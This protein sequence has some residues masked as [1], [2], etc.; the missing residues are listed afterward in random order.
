MR[1]LINAQI[2]GPLSGA[3]RTWPNDRAASAYDPKRSF[4]RA[5]PSDLPLLRGIAL[6][7][8]DQVGNEIGATLILTDTC[9]HRALAL[10]DALSLALSCTAYRLL[11]WLAQNGE[12][13]FD[14]QQDATRGGLDG[15][16]PL[17]D[18][19]PTGFAHCGNSYERRLAGLS[20]ILEVCLNTFHEWTSSRLGGGASNC[21][22]PAARLY[23]RGILAKSGGYRQQH[24]HCKSQIIPSHVGLRSFERADKR[25]HPTVIRFRK[26]NRSPPMLSGVRTRQITIF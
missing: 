6:H 9:G 20:E 10:L 13:F 17:V 3:K 25:N 5:K 21:Y 12:V 2:G 19:R 22:V 23:D 1:V 24:E 7:G 4:A 18:I 15:G 8:L 14:A 16:T 26:C 11:A